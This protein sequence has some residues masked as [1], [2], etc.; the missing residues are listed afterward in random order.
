[1]VFRPFTVRGGGSFFVLSLLLKKSAFVLTEA[2][3]TEDLWRGC[4]DDDLET[5]RVKLH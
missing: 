1:M 5:I 4:Y 3:S 2:H